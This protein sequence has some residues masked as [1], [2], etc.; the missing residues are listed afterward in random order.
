MQNCKSEN[1]DS[2]AIE[3]GNKSNEVDKVNRFENDDKE[4]ATKEHRSSEFS[5][6]SKGH[7]NMIVKVSSVGSFSSIAGVSSSVKSSTDSMP[8]YQSPGS[9]KL[10]SITKSRATSSTD[11]VSIGESNLNEE[12]GNTKTSNSFIIHHRS[13]HA[14]MS[15]LEELNRE[16]KDIEPAASSSTTTTVVNSLV[17]QHIRTNSSNSNTNSSTMARSKEVQL[18]IK[19]PSDLFVDKSVESDKEVEFTFDLVQDDFSVELHHTWYCQSLCIY[20]Y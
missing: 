13:P 10:I 1:F 19:I 16:D 6:L 2:K 8:T 20:V 17:R 3:I 14:S 11:L 5:I 4:E 9:V 18:Q 12:S 7:S 15:A